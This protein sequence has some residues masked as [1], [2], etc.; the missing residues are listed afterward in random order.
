MTSYFNGYFLFGRFVDVS[1]FSW[2]YLKACKVIRDKVADWVERKRKVCE[3]SMNSLI[4]G[5]C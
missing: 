1:P 2:P 5:K 4:V 3:I